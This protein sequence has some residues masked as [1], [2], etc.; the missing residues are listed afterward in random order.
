MERNRAKFQEA[1]QKDN[2]SSPLG[3]ASCCFS[4]ALEPC[5]RGD[6]FIFSLLLVKHKILMIFVAIE[7]FALQKCNEWEL[8]WNITG[9]GGSAR[10]LPPVQGASLWI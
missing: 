3:A 4:G 5:T 8:H 10:A 7:A 2:V 1:A 9:G 6:S